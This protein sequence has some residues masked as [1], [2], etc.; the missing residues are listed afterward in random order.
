MQ[1]LDY[2]DGA[3]CY[4]T[5]TTKM[6]SADDVG[7]T[8]SNSGSISE[9]VLK[10]CIKLHETED[11][12]QT[13]Y[14]VIK[15][16]RMI[17]RA[18]VCTIVL[19]DHANEHYSVLATDHEAQSTIRRVTEI[20]DF[21]AIA[22]SWVSLLGGSD[23]IILTKTESDL[24]YIRGVSDAGYRFMMESDIERIA[25]FP[26]RHNNEVLG[27]I[28]AINYDG[29]N[30]MRIKET[31]ELTTFFV[32]AKISSYNM[33]ERLKKISYSDVLT[34]LPTRFACTDKMIK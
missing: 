24:N 1:P 11:F 17:C 29:S 15:D 13:M 5:Y 9:D 26:L 28:W 10:T 2:E 12:R 4:C 19:L 16:I 32:S 8:S 25:F 20:P 18:E 22:A 31:L 7:L 3:L 27:F 34:E 21:Y 33:M 30:T 6:C 14:E 23:C